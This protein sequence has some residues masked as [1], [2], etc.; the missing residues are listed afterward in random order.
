[1]KNTEGKVLGV[2]QLI[3]AL[4]PNKRNII[5]FDKNL[6]QLMVSFSS[7]ASAALEGYIQEQKLRTEIRQLRIEIDAGKR[8]EQ[9]DQITDSSYF[10][11]LQ[12]KVKEL[13]DIDKKG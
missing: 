9:V 3:N 12:D 13:K 6:Q 5:P 2:L 1:M 8:Q 7:L 4:E 10:R 11:I